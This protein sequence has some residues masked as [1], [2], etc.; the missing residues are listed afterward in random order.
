MNKQ[1]RV[2]QEKGI[3]LI[4]LII[5][6][7]VLLILAVVTINSIQGDGIIKYAQNAADEYTA[8]ADEEQDMLQNYLNVLNEET[9]T[10]TGAGGAEYEA[11]SVETD[12]VKYYAN[13]D[14]DEDP[15]GIIYIDKAKTVSGSWNG[16]SYTIENKTTGL[17]EYYISKE[18]HTTKLGTAPVLSLV[19]GSTGEERFYIMSLEDEKT[20]ASTAFYWYYNAVDQDTYEGKITDYETVTSTGI[21][22]GKTNTEN[23]IDNGKWGSYGDKSDRDMWGLVKEGWYIP[24]KDEWAAF[25]STFGVTSGKYG[26]LGLSGNYWSSSLYDSRYAWDVLFDY[27]AMGNCGISDGDC[28]RLS[29]T[30]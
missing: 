2:R 22:A 16:D 18:S 23:M 28:V 9:K 4:A 20:D 12:C 11:I 10:E 8:K 17:K 1:K 19:P 5:T 26:N 30:F 7:V 13:L 15:E 29:T 3:T 27:D 6:I 14:E 21:G 25:T 24:S